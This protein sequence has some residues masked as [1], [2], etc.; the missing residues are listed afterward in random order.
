MK[1]TSPTGS[2]PVVLQRGKRKLILF[3][4]L[5]TPTERKRK[6]VVTDARTSPPKR[7]Y[8]NKSHP[9]AVAMIS[10]NALISGMRSVPRGFSLLCAYNNDMIISFSVS[11]RTT[12]SPPFRNGEK[13]PSL[14]LVR[15]AHQTHR[16]S[17]PLK[18]S[19][20]P[21]WTTLMAGPD[22]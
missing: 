20:K 15:C 17:R 19:K 22:W 6:M 13:F 9:V 14:S 3:F 12:L 1:K 8:D 4:V 18:K 5:C 16:G 11:L 7:M 10:K 2:V 21:P